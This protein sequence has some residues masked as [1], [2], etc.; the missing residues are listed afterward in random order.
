LGSRVYLHL[1][2]GSTQFWNDA[3]LQKVSAIIHQMK[4]LKLLYHW[5]VERKAPHR[6]C[7]GSNTRIQGFTTATADVSLGVHL[8][9][10]DV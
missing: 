9:D 2:D 4:T 3:A 1:A 10:C 8:W 5:D 6:A 7:N